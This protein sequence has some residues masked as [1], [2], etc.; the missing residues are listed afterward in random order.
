MLPKDYRKT[1]KFSEEIP[2]TTKQFIFQQKAVAVRGAVGALAV[3]LVALIGL[4]NM[5][6]VSIYESMRETGL[7]RALGAQKSDVFLQFMSEGVWLSAIGAVTGLALGAG[8]CYAARTWGGLPITLSAFWTAAGVVA[9][10]LAGMVI[11]LPPAVIA[12]RAQP[13][14]ALRY[15]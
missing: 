3:L 13:V 12:A 2:E 5:L 15:E 14:E 9:T 8:I 6:L 1:I 7:R 11:S 4:A 10:V